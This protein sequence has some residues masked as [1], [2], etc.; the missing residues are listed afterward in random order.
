[1]T[2]VKF[3]YK[4]I[5]VSILLHFVKE[6]ITTHLNASDGCGIHVPESYTGWIL[7]LGFSSKANQDMDILVPIKQ[8]ERVVVLM[9]CIT[10]PN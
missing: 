3:P 5:Y 1:M 4:A 8:V 7:C 9:T 2:P 10:F 6:I